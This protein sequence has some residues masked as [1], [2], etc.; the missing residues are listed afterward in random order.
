MKINRAGDHVAFVYDNIVSQ[1][2]VFTIFFDL[3]FKILLIGI[4]HVQGNKI[5]N[6]T[7]VHDIGQ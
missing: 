4:D 6:P 2:M 7:M 3:S 1:Q 5:P